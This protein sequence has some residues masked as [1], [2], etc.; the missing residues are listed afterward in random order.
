MAEKKVPRFACDLCPFVAQNTSGLTW[1]KIKKHK[2]GTGAFSCPDCT[3]VGINQ[4]GLSHHITRMHK[5]R[6]T[7]LAKPPKQANLALT[8]GHS[9]EEEAH[10]VA[11]SIPEATL[12]LALGRF[13]GLCTAMAVEFDLP[14]RL[15]ASRLAELVFRSQVR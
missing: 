5:N 10:P 9:H 14:P 7:T 6:S 15:F 1:H 3:F 12:A 2:N 11:I 13:Q 4:Q 8:N